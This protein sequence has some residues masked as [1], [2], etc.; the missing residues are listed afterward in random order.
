M[1][2]VG[3]KKGTKRWFPVRSYNNNC[4]VQLSMSHDS[5][6]FDCLSC[7][8]G[9]CWYPYYR[10]GDVTIRIEWGPFRLWKLKGDL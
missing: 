5:P 10:I 8:G 1:K 9:R 6:V 7:K 4:K 3:R 2:L